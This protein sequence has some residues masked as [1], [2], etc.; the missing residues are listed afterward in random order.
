MPASFSTAWGR[1]VGEVRAVRTLQHAAYAVATERRVYPFQVADK[2]AGP[3]V[4]A[5]LRF[6]AYSCCS[7][8]QCCVYSD[9]PLFS[10]FCSEKHLQQ[11]GPWRRWAR[12][13][14]FV[15]CARAGR[16]ALSKL[17][18]ACAPLERPVA[19]MAASRRKARLHSGD[20][21]GR[22]EGEDEGEEQHTQHF[23]FREGRRRDPCGSDANATCRDSFAG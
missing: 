6:V 17:A 20:L 14:P 4:A 3:T 13:Q 11:C 12:G 7:I 10:L 21:E 1:G 22:R 16:D 9:E 18:C 8:V 2:I 5:L 23:I 19:G 15:C